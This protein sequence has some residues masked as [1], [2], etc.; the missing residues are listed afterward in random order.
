M[1]GLLTAGPRS[2]T[3]WLGDQKPRSELNPSIVSVV[4]FA[5]SK[6]NNETV[7]FR[8]A[9]VQGNCLVFF[10]IN[11]STIP[12]VASGYTQIDTDNGTYSGV[13][14]FKIAG[15]SESATQT[16]ITTTASQ[17][18]AVELNSVSGFNANPIDVH[19]FTESTAANPPKITSA[20][21]SPATS[22]EFAL[23][24][25]FQFTTTNAAPT[26]IPGM[27][28]LTGFSS[29]T[30]GGATGN[31]IAAYSALGTG[32]F[33]RTI[34]WGSGTSKV[35]AMAVIIVRPLWTTAIG[36]GPPVQDEQTIASSGTY[37]IAGTG[38]S[39]QD[40]QKI[41]A[42]GNFSSGETG[43]GASSQDHQHVSASGDV[44][45]HGS[46]RQSTGRSA[47]QRR[48][49][50]NDPGKGGLA[51]RRSTRDGLRRAH[52]LGRGGNPAR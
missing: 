13:T 6:T 33:Q 10:T 16:P 3:H 29:T 15:A 17:I 50:A 39:T 21:F 23:A 12:G 2:L 43:T 25:G 40:D 27:Q 42:S 37:A 46:R 1:P 44:N 38:G 52:L 26:A 11:N 47:G 32:K 31:G 36:N 34:T 18:I 20:N 24:F 8:N 4:Q 35:A 51:P 5:V 41:A 48:W 45:S 7:L 49:N 19:G 9:P 14:V 28:T 30:D 22:G